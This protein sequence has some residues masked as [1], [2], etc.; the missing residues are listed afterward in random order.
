MSGDLEPVSDTL[1]E[2]FTRLGLAHPQVMAELS[3]KW[4]D[5]AP[6]PWGGRSRP[7][8]VKGKTLVVEATQPSLVAFLR[9]GI[10]ALLDSLAKRFGEGVVTV[11]EVVPPGRR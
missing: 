3:Q 7:V 9:Y 4:D 8:L 6:S 11:V 2:V 1:E 5:I 10:T